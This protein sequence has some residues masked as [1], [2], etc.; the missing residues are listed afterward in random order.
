MIRSRLRKPTS[1]STM[2]VLY[3][4]RA[5]PVPMAALVVVLPTPPLPE[6]MT[7]IFAK[8]TFLTDLEFDCY[9][10]PDNRCCVPCVPACL[11]RSRSA[12]SRG[13]WAS[14]MA[15]QYLSKGCYLQDV[16]FE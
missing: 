4:R 6:V 13:S 7:R 8:M 3:P 9:G 1:K 12:L 11:G 5:S 10:A 14:R 16:T 2:T 15:E